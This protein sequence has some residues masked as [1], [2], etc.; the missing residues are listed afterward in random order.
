MSLES[1]PGRVVVVTH[2]KQGV[3]VLPLTDD[4]STASVATSSRL[5]AVLPSSYR[6]DALTDFQILRAA[7]NAASRAGA[8]IVVV[9]GLYR[10][11][12]DI[13][14]LRLGVV[15]VSASP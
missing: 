6:V 7:S 14:Q 4:A 12:N 11:D 9:S 15:E 8:A 10:D 5:E 1:W 3:H 13:A 2:D